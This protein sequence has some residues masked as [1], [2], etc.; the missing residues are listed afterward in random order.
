MHGQLPQDYYRYCPGEAHLKLS[1]AVCR[2]RRRASFHKCRG[3]Q[4][5]DDEI[6]ARRLA[7]TPAPAAETAP[8]DPAAAPS[9]EPPSP[10][11]AARLT[12][13]A[14]PTSDQALIELIASGGTR[15]AA[16]TERREPIDRLF[17]STDI[18]GRWP[19]PLSEDLAWR[20]GH[21]A[22]Q[23]LRSKLK[24]YER[25]DPRARVLLTGRDRRACSARLHD[26][27]LRGV[28][29]TGVTV[30]DLG[31]IDTPQMFFAVRHLGACGGI[32]TTGGRSPAEFSGFKLCGVG[33]RDVAAV[34]G[35][36]DIRDIAR[37]VPLHDTGTTAE[38]LPLELSKPY[39]EFV[40]RFLAAPSGRSVA[41]VV[42]TAGGAASGWVQ[43][44]F[45]GR[46]DIRLVPVN[47]A[48]GDLPPGETPA[49]FDPDPTNP[50]ALAALR[51]TIRAEKADA[52][53][54]FD[55]DGDGCVFL[56]ER[57]APIR[58][59]YLIALLARRFLATAAGAGIV[60]DWRAG[61]ALREEI[62]RA[63]G[64]ARAEAPDSAAIRK[65]MTET[66]AVLGANMSG[67]FFFRENGTCESGLLAL[68]YFI[69]MLAAETKRLSERVKPLAKYKSSGDR[70]IECADPARLMEQVAAHFGASAQ[71]F[72][73][74]VYVHDAERSI[75][76]ERA[77]ADAAAL[78]FRAEA[79]TAEVLKRTIE[80]LRPL[81]AE[82]QPVVTS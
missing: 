26:A 3:C 66:Q 52:G 80:E 45:A 71:R 25:A 14:R 44:A 8:A 10:G 30:C 31:V 81:L 39:R 35:L 29:S 55:G 68:A 78:T 56:D 32:V 75:H 59:D 40:Q 5:N 20:I 37:R 24:G 73:G 54:R 17:R 36:I 2:G 42:D 1:D 57:G 72:S 11:T 12:V 58:A 9:S 41:I 27:L 38:Q 47:D 76:I 19:T 82:P 21:A 64:V 79:A 18:R 23:F 28:C 67:Q 22:A 74:G 69:N 48:A 65:T 7:D 6:A 53:V 34:T 62:E 46:D 15:P 70:R 50:A 60:I 13:A 33:G 4:F 49:A 77:G 43:T 16:G 51:E 63:G 61:R